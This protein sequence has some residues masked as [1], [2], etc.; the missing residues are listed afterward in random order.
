MGRT[1]GAIWQQE[2]T[3]LHLEQRTNVYISPAGIGNDAFLMCGSVHLV[4]NYQNLQ[5]GEVLG[6]LPYCAPE[7]RSS[8]ARFVARF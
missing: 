6:C 7:V 4:G 2:H 1:E 8:F 5:Y 3:F